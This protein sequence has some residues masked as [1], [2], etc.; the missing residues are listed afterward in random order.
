MKLTK[1]CH[2]GSRMIPSLR[3]TW[4]PNNFSK[5]GLSFDRFTKSGYIWGGG[6]GGGG[7]GGAAS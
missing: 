2:K 7:G 4:N 1:S 6:G 5:R 3:R